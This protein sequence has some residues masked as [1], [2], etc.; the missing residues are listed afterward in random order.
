[1]F[2]NKKTNHIK[3]EN[4]LLD[5][6]KAIYFPIPKVACSSMKKFCADLL[7][8]KTDHLIDLDEEIH[9]LKFPFIPNKKIYKKYKNY[10]KF[11]F[12]RNPWH[13][14]LSCYLNKIKSEKNYNKTPY[15]NGVFN[16][17]IKFNKF[18][19]GMSFR[20]FV[21]AIAEI[22]DEQANNHFKSQ[23]KFLEDAKGN[24]LPD[25]VGKI[26]NM[27]KDFSFVCSKL[28]INKEKF[29]LPHLMQTKNA[30]KYDSYFTD[31]EKKLIAKRY[32]KDIELFKYE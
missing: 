23:Y 1:M 31:Y 14:T 9:Y 30:K 19:A 25:F 16:G 13:R 15:T 22:N 4:I 11:A 20:E 6:Y 32:K 12:V 17:F 21:E 18:W 10:F 7:E 28:N 24:W 5:K 29:I 26:E 8:I 3:E 2:K 27:E